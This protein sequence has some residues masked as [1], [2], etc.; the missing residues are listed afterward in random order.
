MT[1]GRPQ[2]SETE[3]NWRPSVAKTYIVTNHPFLASWIFSALMAQLVWHGALASP[4]PGFDPPPGRHAGSAATD[5]GRAHRPKAGSIFGPNKLICERHTA[6]QT[7]QI[8]LL[9]EICLVEVGGL[10][11]CFFG[12][13]FLLLRLRRVSAITIFAALLFKHFFPSRA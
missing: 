1:V 12:F 10:S 9:H 11:C 2:I 4:G 8:E 3:S 13:F 5:H 7:G 6:G